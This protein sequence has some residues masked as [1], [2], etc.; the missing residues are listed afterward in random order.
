MKTRHPAT[1]IVTFLVVFGILYGLYH[2]AEPWLPAYYAALA[3]LVCGLLGWIDPAVG[4]ESNYLLYNGQRELVVVEGCDGVTF[5]ILIIA[6]VLPFPASWR[7]K[8]LGLLWLLPAVLLLNW[9]RLVVLAVLRFYV[10]DWFDFA[11]VY[12]FQPVMIAF[13]LA[14]V[15][16]WLA[17]QGPRLD[18][19]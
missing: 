8:L 14:I 4:C 1:Y 7:S 16:V 11:H 10:P 9:L 6:A 13:T 12:L 18:E 3:R 2:L 15:A 19:R 17:S 5:V